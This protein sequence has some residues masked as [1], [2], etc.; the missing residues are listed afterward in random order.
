M[1][2]REA[3]LRRSASRAG[4]STA[5]RSARASSARSRARASWPVRG[6]ASERAAAPPRPRA[7]RA[8]RERARARRWRAVLGGGV[9]GLALVVE[10]VERSLS[11]R[12]PLR[13]SSANAQHL[14][15]PNGVADHR[16]AAGVLAR[17]DAL[18]DLDLALAREQRDLAHLAQVDAHG[19][20]AVRLV[21][22]LGRRA[23]RRARASRTPARHDAEAA[24][25][26]ERR[27][28]PRAASAASRLLG[29]AQP[30]PRGCALRRA[31]CVDACGIGGQRRAPLLC[32]RSASAAT[33]APSRLG[34][35]AARRLAARTARTP[36]CDSG[37][38][39]ALASH[40]GRHFLGSLRG[41]AMTG[42]WMPRPAATS[43]R[44]RSFSRKIAC[45]LRA[46]RAGSVSA[47]CA[48]GGGACSSLAAMSRITRARG[49]GIER[50]RLPPRVRSSSRRFGAEPPLER[51]ETTTRSP[52]RRASSARGH[53]LA[54][55]LGRR[56][57]R[58][59]SPASIS[60]PP[61]GA[62]GAPAR[63]ARER[64]DRRAPTCRG[65]G[66]RARRPRRCAAARRRAAQPRR[67]L[68]SRRPRARAAAPRRC[69]RPARR[70]ARGAA[71]RARRASA[72]CSGVRARRAPPRA[73]ITRSSAARRASTQRA[74][75]VGALARE[76]ACR[77]RR[78]GGSTAARTRRPSGSRISSARAPRAGRP[79]RRRRAARPGA[80]GGGA[81]ARGPR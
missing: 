27:A 36:G 43:R 57:A 23:R 68:A 79:R 81:R 71:R 11:S 25:A 37:F 31:V 76:Q 55:R 14:A 19:I 75:R 29:R 22:V 4:S 26:E 65:R 77:D 39:R 13:S 30:S 9:R 60:R 17:L 10:P 49:L 15:M 8:A 42:R 61:P 33:A 45:T 5:W 52:R 41:N 44:Y 54:R 64:G 32:R 1:I 58:R 6:F 48:P 78:R 2:S 3:R 51:G 63:A 18:R 72:F 66:H 62:R 56:S 24:L 50:A 73:A 46:E 12:L 67:R 16:V 35:R 20:V 69:A 80:C 7:A 53:E 47:R 38:L 34:R 40:G 70:R 74:Q 28:P 59:R 21:D